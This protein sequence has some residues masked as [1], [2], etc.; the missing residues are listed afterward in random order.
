MIE[1]E[2]IANSATAERRL[3][4]EVLALL[5]RDAVA[6]RAGGGSR[7]A[8][9]GELAAAFADVISVGPML[10]HCCHWLD[11]EPEAVSRAFVCW[12]ERRGA[13]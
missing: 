13:A 12:C 10:R 5:V 7:G 6:Y 8:E 2:P 1:L 9:A 11:C 3:W 4:G